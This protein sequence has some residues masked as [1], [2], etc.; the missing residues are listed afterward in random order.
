MNLSKKD[1]TLNF[2]TYS[3]I[4]FHAKLVYF[5]GANVKE[6]SELN[7]VYKINQTIQTNK[8]QK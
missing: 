7:N 1:L 4:P 3:E 5:F 2:H 8:T 6:T